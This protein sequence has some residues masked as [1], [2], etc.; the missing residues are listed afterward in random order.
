MDDI[1]DFDDMLG[2]SPPIPT[3]PH[4]DMFKE[5]TTDRNFSGKSISPK[6]YNYHYWLKHELAV[7]ETLKEA[8]II[9]V[10]VSSTAS[11]ATISRKHLVRALSR[12][13]FLM[14]AHTKFHNERAREQGKEVN[15]DQ[16]LDLIMEHEGTK[17][18]IE[19]HNILL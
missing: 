13:F 7:M 10:Q 18:L 9:P 5:W 4:N 6:I 17:K 3:T 19:N 12:H 14:H 8:S 1:L 11:M 16:F 15:I 2:I